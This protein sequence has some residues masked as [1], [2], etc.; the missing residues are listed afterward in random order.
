MA[1]DRGLPKLSTGDGT[2]PV[3]TPERF[4]AALQQFVWINGRQCG[5]EGTRGFGEADAADSTE[6]ENGRAPPSSPLATEALRA[7]QDVLEESKRCSCCSPADPVAEAGLFVMRLTRLMEQ[8]TLARVQDEMHLRLRETTL[9]TCVPPSVQSPYA[10]REETTSASRSPSTLRCCG[11]RYTVPGASSSSFS[12]S[13]TASAL[14]VGAML[15]PQ[16]EN[17]G[18]MARAPIWRFH[19]DLTLQLQQCMFRCIFLLDKALVNLSAD[20]GGLCGILTH[21][22]AAQLQEMFISAITESLSCARE[23]WKADGTVAGS[24]EAAREV[25]VVLE[26]LQQAAHAQQHAGMSPQLHVFE[27]SAAECIRCSPPP[28]TSWKQSP[29][30]L[31]GGCESGGVREAAS[32]LSVSDNRDDIEW[33]FGVVG[34]DYSAKLVAQQLWCAEKLLSQRFPSYAS[35]WDRLERARLCVE[36]TRSPTPTV[37][38]SDSS[39]RP[40]AFG[41]SAAA[42]TS[43]NATSPERAPRHDGDTP[44]P[45]ITTTQPKSD[46]PFGDASKT[47]PPFRSLTYSEDR[48]EA[49]VEAED[50]AAVAALSPNRRP[51]A[52]PSSPRHVPAV[53]RLLPAVRCVLWEALVAGCGLSAESTSAAVQRPIESLIAT[54]VQEAPPQQAPTTS[55]RA[56][57]YL[58]RVPLNQTYG[59]EHTSN[60]EKAFS[61]ETEHDVENSNFSLAA[62]RA[63]ARS[64]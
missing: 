37:P 2:Y 36:S 6:A 63:Y 14:D 10:P 34:R 15:E 21:T 39:E 16:L 41:A 26:R 45:C 20:D 30:L 19:A 1:F 52:S 4:A 53:P 27:L 13:P 57:R 31:V 17:S 47:S 25:S 43:S 24:A 56:H 59:K 55:N 64:S 42:V 35:S 51:T 7:L 5:D 29:S 22:R 11:R 18:N 46:R 12:P 23:K 3:S 28:F 60:R 50:E 58:Q 9:P 54:Q 40:T 38:R 44:P 8:R 33:C 48:S 61:I 62:G 49:T 32:F